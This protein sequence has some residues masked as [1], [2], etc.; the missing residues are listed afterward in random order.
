MCALP[1]NEN[2]IPIKDEIRAAVWRPGI[3]TLH[4]EPRVSLRNRLAWFEL[5]DHDNA[6]VTHGREATSL[7]RDN[8]DVICQRSYKDA[9]GENKGLC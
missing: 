5:E 2:F 7:H 4:S 3:M 1:E 9:I 6:L 8:A